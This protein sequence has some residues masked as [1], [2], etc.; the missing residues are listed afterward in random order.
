MADAEEAVYRPVLTARELEEIE[1]LQAQGLRAGI[2]YKIDPGTKS[3]IVYHCGGSLRGF[4]TAD[5][6]GGAEIESAAIAKSQADWEQLYA[7]LLAHVKE[8]QGEKILFICDPNDTLV[9]GILENR[10]LAPT[11]AEYRMTLVPAAFK[12]MQ[13]RGVTLRQADSSDRAYIAAVEESVFGSSA[14]DMPEEELLCTRIIMQ[15]DGPAA[16]PV[17]KLRV[18]E[19]DGLCGIYGVAVEKDRQNRGIGGAALTVLL[20]D[21]IKQGKKHFYLEV[22]SE[23]P[24][25]FHLYQKLGFT[26]SAEFRYYPCEM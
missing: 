9:Q 25:A 5:Q 23:N 4:M 19:T 14:A 10:G 21:L 11:F 12:P 17:G 24:S 1:N 16:L 20:Q 3:G 22:D 2:R 26:V 8:K 18:N 15:D 7:A 13:V 6:F